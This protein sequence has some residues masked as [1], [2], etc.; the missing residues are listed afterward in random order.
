MSALPLMSVSSPQ[1][2]WLWGS[3]VIVVLDQATKQIAEAQLTPHQPVNL[4]PFFD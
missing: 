2:K 3:L 4:L 1:M